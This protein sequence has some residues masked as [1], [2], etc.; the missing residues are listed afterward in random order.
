MAVK[1]LKPTN[2]GT[3]YNKDEIAGFSP[4]IEEALVKQG[5]AEKV[6]S[7]AGAKNEGAKNDGGKGG[8]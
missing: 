3:L 4:E 5:D 2:V 7:R 1:F 6:P 8:N